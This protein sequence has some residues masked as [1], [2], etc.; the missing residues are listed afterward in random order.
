MDRFPDDFMFELSKSEWTEVITI[1]DNLS[2]TYKYSPAMPF[3]FTEHGITMLSSVLKSKTAVKVN[4]AVV[5]AFIFLKQHNNNLNLVH[6]RIN[7]IEAKF[8]TKIKN[9]D[10]II[11]FLLTQPELI[12][13]AN[14]PV[15]KP[16]TK[17][18]GFQTER[19]KS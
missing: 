3:A 15:E 11:N 12:V 10:E 13:S 19:N 18:I 9:I 2:N 14:K 5:R 7:E 16:V 8:N 4:I 6:Q 1:C 17:V